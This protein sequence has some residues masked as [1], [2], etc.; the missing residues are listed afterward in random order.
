MREKK[1]KA[2]MVIELNTQEALGKISEMRVDLQLPE[3]QYA[4]KEQRDYDMQRNYNA[5]CNYAAQETL[6]PVSALS[7]NEAVYKKQPEEN[8]DNRSPEIKRA[9]VKVKG[10]EAYVTTNSVR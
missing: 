8:C 7:R 9:T 10:V 1:A 5:Q 2:E 4:K 6:S 3:R